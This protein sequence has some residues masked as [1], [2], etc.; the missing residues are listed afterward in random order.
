MDNLE[1][2]VFVEDLLSYGPKHPVKDKFNK[3]QFIADIDKLVNNLRQNGVNGEKLCE[4]EASAKWY[5]KN[6]RETP[7]D[8]GLSKVTKYLKEHDLLAVPFDNG[9]AF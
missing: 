3:T 7:V 2:P 4:I 5:A 1:L 9:N 6:Q 8:R